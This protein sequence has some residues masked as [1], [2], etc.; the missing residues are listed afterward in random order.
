MNNQKKNSI[1]SVDVAVGIARLDKF[2]EFSM[3]CLAEMSD[4]ICIDSI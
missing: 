2:M 4:P 3:M 1:K